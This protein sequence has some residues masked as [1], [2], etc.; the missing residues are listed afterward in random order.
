MIDDRAQLQ[1]ALRTGAVLSAADLS[2]PSIP[3]E[4]VRS[5]LVEEAVLHEG[6][7]ID[8]RGLQLTGVILEGDLCLANIKHLP[9]LAFGDVTITGHLDLSHSAINGGLNIEGGSV[10]AQLDG[11]G[12]HV[13]RH[14]YVYDVDF[15]YTTDAGRGFK[16][17]ILLSG[18]TVGEFLQ[19]YVDVD[20]VTLSD[21][22]VGGGNSEV[23]G[24]A[25]SIGL[26]ESE[27]SSVDLNGTSF[28]SSV[29]LQG[30]FRHGIT[31]RGASVR[32]TLDLGS[33]T[34]TSWIRRGRLTDEG[35]FVDAH[36]AVAETFILPRDTPDSAGVD[37]T[38]AEIGQLIVHVTGEDNCPVGPRIDAT[39]GW[40]LGS[41][42]MID[43]DR[44]PEAV[45]I[46]NIASDEAAALVAW[47]PNGGGKAFPVMAW[48]ALAAALADEGREGEARW[49]RIEAAD[50]HKRSTA[51][52]VW[53]MVGRSITKST[54][55]HG[56]SPF[57]ALAWLAGLWAVATSLA[58]VAW[59][60]SEDAFVNNSGVDEPPGLWEYLY[61]LDITVSPVG[62]F[63]ADIWM[64]S[65]WWLALAFWVLKAASYALFGLFIAGI[66]GRAMKTS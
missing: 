15:S 14:V 62:S 56:Y 41:L 23:D 49:L 55:G 51:D 13:K 21:A 7:H 45:P 61:A 20:N 66:S 64:P 18:A 3:S 54:I 57:R 16:G 8:P 37:L 9:A 31:L 63:Q 50:R 38:D 59:R 65:W 1:R 60:S 47:L 43:I 53:A 2:S 32:G 58:V 29:C 48:R 12:L 30:T 42:A 52:S 36:E 10:R 24:E 39:S 17:E 5:V 44:R 27:F 35:L 4:M 19:L 6:R 33:A 22:K 25:V 34:L 28:Q 40:T 26:P 46:P 11:S